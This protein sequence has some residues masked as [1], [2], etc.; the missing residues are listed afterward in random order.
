MSC[1]FQNGYLFLVC[2]VFF[3]MK[4]C[5]ILSN[6]FFACG[7]VLYCISPLYCI[8]RFSYA[9][10]ALHSCNKSHFIMV[11]NPLYM[12]LNFCCWDFCVYIHKGYSSKLWCLC[13]ILVVEWFC[14]HRIYWEEFPP[15]ICEVLEEFVKNRLILL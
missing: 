2:Q 13:V 12:L 5:W 1:G 11:H 9:E 4:L 3:I 15:P 14:P 10:P 6:A 7:F 8:D